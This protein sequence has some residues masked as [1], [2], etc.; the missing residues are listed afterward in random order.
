[1]EEKK[2]KDL[3]FMLAMKEKWKKVCNKKSEAA[4]KK[5]KGKKLE[6]ISIPSRQVQAATS[7]QIDS[8]N[9]YIIYFILK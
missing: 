6:E 3:M 9:F 2:H 7:P 4:Q 1:M 5:R 8:F